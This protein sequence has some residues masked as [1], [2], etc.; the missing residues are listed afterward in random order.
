MNRRVRW[1]LPGSTHRAPGTPLH[2]SDR[3]SFSSGGNSIPTKRRSIASKSSG[4]QRQDAGMAVEA[5]A[6]NL[7]IREEPDQGEIAE[8]VADHLGLDPGLAKERRAAG[9]AADVDPGLGRAGEPPLQL[10]QHA[11]HIGPG[12]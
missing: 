6:R 5:I 10:A 1:R 7:A 9:D 11:A 4:E 2:K 3:S 8:S 12:A